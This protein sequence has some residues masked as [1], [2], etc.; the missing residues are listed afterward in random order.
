MGSKLAM[1]AWGTHAAMFSAGELTCGFAMSGTAASARN[2]NSLHRNMRPPR[3]L[4]NADSLMI[5]KAGSEW[6][7]HFV[8]RF[9]CCGRKTLSSKSI[10][11][12]RPA[13]LFRKP[14]AGNLNR[15]ALRNASRNQNREEGVYF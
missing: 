4:L 1:Y 6:L 8:G 3:A 13:A 5:R 14:L 15:K 11:L 10:P 2:H 12:A 7:V 9:P